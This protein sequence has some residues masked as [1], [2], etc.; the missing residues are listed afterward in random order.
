[1]DNTIKE[2]QNVVIVDNSG[3]RRVLKI[4]AGRKIKHFK[5]MLDLGQLVGK[6]FGSHHLVVD[7]KSGDIEEI[8]DVKELTKAFLDETMF[9]SDDEAD[10]QE[11]NEDI[12]EEVKDIELLHSKD[13]RDIVDNN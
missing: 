4:K 10:A 6:Q 8:T 5:V 9:G 3:N 2:G 7:P 1:M 12:E 11:E 13:N